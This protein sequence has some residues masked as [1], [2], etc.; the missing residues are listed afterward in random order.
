MNES[1]ITPLEPVAQSLLNACGRGTLVSLEPLAGGRNNRVYR[2]TSDQTT[3]ILKQYYRNPAGGHDRFA[4]E[5]AWCEFCDHF[6][7]AWTPVLWARDDAV[8]CALFEELPGRAVRIE[9]V[10]AAAVSQAADFLSAVN[11]HRFTPEAERLPFAAEACFTWRDHIQTVERRLARLSAIVPGDDMD[12]DMLAWMQTELTPVWQQIQSDVQ[13]F[14]TEQLE[15]PLS[16]VEQCLSPSDFGFHNAWRLPNG[17]L[18]F[19]DFEYAGWDDPA[20][21]LCDFY[22]QVDLP[23]PRETWPTMIAAL[24]ND[25]GPL[26][27][28]V[29]RLFPVYGI[30][31]CSIVLNEFLPSGRERRHFAG[32]GLKDRRPVQ[33]DKARA[34][35]QDV[36]AAMKSPWLPTPG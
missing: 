13:G 10:N 2:V 23:A 36:V 6:R 16:R 9:D 1:A 22:W 12:R 14:G 20:K 11:D 24:T 3:A 30:K 26:A 18:R 31:W 7:F 21:L 34:L 15:Q 27:E 25:P 32:E 29:E 28:R 5:V 4:S 8:A 33:L 19:L 35:L 17:E